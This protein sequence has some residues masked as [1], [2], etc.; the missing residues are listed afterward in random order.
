MDIQ[1]YATANGS[2]T[3]DEYD[4]TKVRLYLPMDKDSSRDADGNVVFDVYYDG[5]PLMIVT[6]K[7]TT[8]AKRS[9][10][11]S[12]FSGE[13]AEDNRL[14]D[15]SDNYNAQKKKVTKLQALVDK[16]KAYPDGTS[17]FSVYNPDAKQELE[18]AVDLLEA[19][20]QSYLKK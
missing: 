6:D 8:V 11:P 10:A 15:I 9:V 4:G 16:Q 19:L 1:H 17:G 7:G 2:F 12:E 14:S 3:T 5:L 20:M 13:E 18:D